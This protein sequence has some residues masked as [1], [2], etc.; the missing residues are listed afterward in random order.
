MDEALLSVKGLGVTLNNHKLL[1]DVAFTLNKG[2]VMAIIGPNG[3]GK[4]TLFRALLGLIPY[5]GTIEWEK[6]VKIGYVPQKLYIENDLPLTTREFFLLKNVNIKDA[7]SK[8]SAVG[9]KEKILDFKMGQLSGGELQRVLV[10]W[11]LLG[12]PDVL[13]FDE[14]TAG[15]DWEGE[16]TI[17]SMLSKLNKNNKLSILLISHELEI[18]NRYAKQVVCL[19]KN[20]VCYGPPKKVLTKEAIDAMF[21]EEVHFYK[22]HHI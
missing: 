21:G 4:T 5:T 16:E 1:N 15:V 12:N 8:L 3:A 18:V 7:K 17:Y 19:N 9:L 11:S 2:E 20:Q 22:H 10:A 14:P 6:S 13:L